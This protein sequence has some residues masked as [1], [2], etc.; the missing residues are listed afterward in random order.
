MIDFYIGHGRAESG[1]SALDINL[2]IIL[3]SAILYRDIRDWERQAV[4][5]P[6]APCCE[7]VSHV[8][9]Q[10]PHK[11]PHI[12][13]AFTYLGDLQRDAPVILVLQS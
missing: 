6:A 8:G 4:G 2:I 5:T 12:R 9:P 3:S 7:L 10:L 13:W 11:Q 1:G